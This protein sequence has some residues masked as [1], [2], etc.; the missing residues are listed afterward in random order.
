MYINIL[1]LIKGFLL[2]IQKTF[3]QLKTAFINFSP[4]YTENL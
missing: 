2:Y 4:I 3:N 1:K